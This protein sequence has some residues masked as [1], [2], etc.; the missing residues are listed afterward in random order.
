MSFAASIAATPELSAKAEYDLAQLDAA[1]EPY[2][3]ARRY[4]NFTEV[5]ANPAAFY[6]PEVLDRLRAVK[7]QVDPDNLFRSN[8]PIY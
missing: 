3:D 4:L 2:G 1:L 7:A 8:H 5:R 6:E